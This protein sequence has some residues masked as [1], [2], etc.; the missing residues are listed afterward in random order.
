MIAPLLQRQT[1]SFIDDNI[2]RR[3]CLWLPMSHFFLFICTIMSIC[4]KALFHACI[5]CRCERIVQCHC[6]LCLV[7]RRK[8]CNAKETF[9]SSPVRWCFTL[10]FVL[11]VISY[12][13]T[14]FGFVPSLLLQAVIHGCLVAVGTISEVMPNDW[15]IYVFFFQGT[16]ERVKRSK[17]GLWRS[18]PCVHKLPQASC[19]PQHTHA[20]TQKHRASNSL[21]C[22]LL[23]N[24]WNV[25]L[26]FLIA[27]AVTLS[28][29][30][31]TV[32]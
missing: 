22:H 29:P 24:L 32:K 12:S 16:W 3:C 15:P 28:Q 1:L 13:R 11:V 27:T 4:V 17:S 9:S 20:R 18:R 26:L 10:L 2:N 6:V 7:P 21:A 19:T 8:K 14:W 30:N 23:A 5:W 25:S 31:C